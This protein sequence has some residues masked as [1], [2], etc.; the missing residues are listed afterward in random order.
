[1][2]KILLKN[3]ENLKDAINFFGIEWAKE[4]KEEIKVFPCILVSFYANDIEFG[5]IYRFTG[6]E[7]SDFHE[8]IIK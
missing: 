3:E 2:E 8:S 1:M 7:I 5:E 4:I 6:V